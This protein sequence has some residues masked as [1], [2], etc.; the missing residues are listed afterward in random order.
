MRGDDMRYFWPGEVIIVAISTAAFVWWFGWG[1]YTPGPPEAVVGEFLRAARSGDWGRAQAFMTQHIQGRVSREGFGAMQ[2][3]LDSRLE[4]FATFEIV[5]TVPRGDEVDVVARLLLP[6]PPGQAP[7][8]ATRP[9]SH[10]GPGRPEGANFVHAHRF[11]LQRQGRGAWR[12]YQFEEV[13]ER[14]QGSP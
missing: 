4:P 14:V 13:D 3:F 7:A 5:R 6:I 2:R 1:Q 9:G 10:V 12:I 8:A 11:Q